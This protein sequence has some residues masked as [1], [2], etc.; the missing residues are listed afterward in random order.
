M[1]E[2]PVVENCKIVLM[3]VRLFKCLYYIIIVVTFD[4]I[5][6]CVCVP[7]RVSLYEIALTEEIYDVFG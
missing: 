1:G 6:Y 3:L 4:R 7:L 5:E 2:N